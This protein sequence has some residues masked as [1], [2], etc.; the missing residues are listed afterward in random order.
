MFRFMFLGTAQLVVVAAASVPAS[1][2]SF[3][4]ADVVRTHSALDI[5]PHNTL[6][7][8]RQH[9]DKMMSIAHEPERSFK[10]IVASWERN[11]LIVSPDPTQELIGDKKGL[12]EH[13]GIL[14]S[15]GGL[16]DVGRP[17]HYQLINAEGHMPLANTLHP[18]KMDNQG[19]A[20]Q[21][22]D[23]QICV[24]SMSKVVTGLVALMTMEIFAKFGLQDKFNCD[25]DVWEYATEE[26]L[27]KAEAAF[28]SRKNNG[29]YN[30][31][32][33]LVKTALK[34]Q[35]PTKRGKATVK[36]CLTHSGGFGF[37]GYHEIRHWPGDQDPRVL[38]PP[39]GGGP[40]FLYGTGYDVVGDIL[41]LV[42]Q[43]SGLQIQRNGQ[44]KTIG[45]DA[46]NWATLND[47]ARNLLFQP[48]G[49]KNTEYK[50]FIDV[51]FQDVN[52][53]VSTDQCPRG[54]DPIQWIHG[55]E[56]GAASL[57]YYAVTKFVDLKGK[58]Q[59]GGATLFT[60]T[61]DFA[62]FMR[63]LLK[64]GGSLT[65]AVSGDSITFR[66]ESSLQPQSWGGKSERYLEETNF[67]EWVRKNHLHDNLSSG[68]LNSD[69]TSPKRLDGTS[70]SGPAPRETPKAQLG[71]ASFGHS[72][73][74]A[75]AQKT[76]RNFVTKY[77][78]N[79]SWTTN[80]VAH[81]EDF[82]S[83]DADQ[84]RFRQYLAFKQGEDGMPEYADTI[85]WRGVFGSAW[86]IDYEKGYAFIK[87]S[88]NVASL[89]AAS[90]IY[91]TRLRTQSYVEGISTTTEISDTNISASE[92]L[93][94][95]T[96][97]I[98]GAGLNHIVWTANVADIFDAVV[99]AESTPA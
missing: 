42:W 7:F 57:G 87:I 12:F 90:F 58:Y 62:R 94:G 79:T 45:E 92:G 95:H 31:F 60:S 5:L 78:G 85:Q 67:K 65:D 66:N 4:S 51:P 53:M 77:T 68:E 37:G 29:Q 48:L 18:K 38:D 2:S 32:Q 93:Y 49:M 1:E 34:A 21:D 43:R 40:F 83:S 44:W 73:I 26:Q 6:N 81:L 14:G 24:F 16:R 35:Y 80:V 3:L 71:D 64:E 96:R 82:G 15:M 33:R 52:R 69:G 86:E 13:T 75:V 8:V 55:I 20:Q 41:P 88:R 10:D 28:E 56:N 61:N 91:Q 76:D 63:V 9:G 25:T 47:V 97:S 36:Q 54:F 99:K 98:G 17:V 59:G 84:T 22:H 11:L 19:D 27:Q 74:C 50:N 89:F 39:S 70:K 23:T 30:T 46:E 72:M